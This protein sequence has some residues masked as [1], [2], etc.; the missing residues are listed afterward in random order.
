RRPLVFEARKGTVDVDATE[1][2]VA[3]ILAAVF[4]TAADRRFFD[5]DG[6]KSAQVHGRVLMGLGANFKLTAQSVTDGVPK[7]FTSEELAPIEAAL[8]E[9]LV[10]VFST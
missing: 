1:S 2:F 6:D 5:A 4:A 8:N 10:S 7:F 9:C 3:K